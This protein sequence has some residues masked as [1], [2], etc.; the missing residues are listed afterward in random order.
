MSGLRPGGR[1]APSGWHDPGPLIPSGGALPPLEELI[2]PRH[3]RRGHMI[4]TG[5]YP[6]H[7]RRLVHRFDREQVLWLSRGEP[8]EAPACVAARHLDLPGVDRPID[9]VCLEQANPAGENHTP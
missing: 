5:D 4:S 9:S 8:G 3:A 2:E 1:H 6:G 7:P